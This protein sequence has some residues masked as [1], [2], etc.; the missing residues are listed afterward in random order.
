MDVLEKPK[1]GFMLGQS[2]P[3]IADSLEDSISTTGFLEGDGDFQ[4]GLGKIL[5]HI[6]IYIITPLD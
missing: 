5:S 3:V 4:P 2:T 1:S 6:D